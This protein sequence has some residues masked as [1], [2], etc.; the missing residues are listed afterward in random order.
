MSLVDNLIKDGWL[1]TPEIINAF[2]KIKRED[3]LPE[4]SKN[5]AELNEALPIGLGQ[6]ISQ[7]L[8]V[9]FMLELLQPK[10]GDKILDVGAGSGWTSAL[11]AEITGDKGKVVAI[12][13]IP[14]LAEFGIKNLTKYNFIE[15]RIIKYICA[16]GSKGFLPAG[17]Q[18]KKNSQNTEI[19]DKILISASS[20]SGVSMELKEQLRMGGRT[21][22]PIKESIWLYIKKLENEFE[23]K[24]YPGFVFVPLV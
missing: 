24:E 15:K 2:K 21:V 12:E 20:P 10:P 6:T 11:L 16:N 23:K 5:L 18:V 9:A 4:E 22:C 8:T 17:R 7:P 1:K 19:Y 13:F 3:F 14:E